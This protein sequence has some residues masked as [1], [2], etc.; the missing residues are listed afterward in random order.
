MKKVGDGIS[1]AWN[2][3]KVVALI[4]AAIDRGAKEVAENI[5]RSAQASTSFKD[6]TGRLRSSIKMAKSKFKNGGYIVYADAPHAHLI[7][8]GHKGGFG[9]GVG[10]KPFMRNALKKNIAQGKQTIMNHINRATG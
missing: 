9:G 6:K 8:F 10:P 2:D 5:L 3:K 1:I 7:E 4:E